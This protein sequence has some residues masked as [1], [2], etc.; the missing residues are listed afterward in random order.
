MLLKV[1]FI[2][3]RVFFYVLWNISAGLIL[4]YFAAVGRKSEKK[5][6]ILTPA[7]PSFTAQASDGGNSKH[8]FQEKIYLKSKEFQAISDAALVNLRQF[9]LFSWLIDSMNPGGVGQQ[10]IFILFDFLQTLDF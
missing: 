1:Y 8:H 7:C 10:D 2:A 6:W 5:G 3:E 9:L 4:H